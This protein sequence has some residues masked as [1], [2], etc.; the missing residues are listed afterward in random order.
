MGATSFGKLSLYIIRAFNKICAFNKFGSH[1]S[2]SIR[3]SKRNGIFSRAVKFGYAVLVL[4]GIFSNPVSAHTGPAI[5]EH[6]DEL[7]ELVFLLDDSGSMGQS[8][9]Q[10]QQEGFKQALNDIVDKGLSDYLNTVSVI[11]FGSSAS[12]EINQ[13]TDLSEIQTALSRAYNGGSTN[14]TGAFLNA[15]QIFNGIPDPDSDGH[16]VHKLLVLSTDGRP[17]S[18]SSALQAANQLQQDGVKIASVFVGSSSNSGISFL[19]SFSDNNPVP[20]PTNFNDFGSEVSE[21]LLLQ[22]SERVGTPVVSRF[23]TSVDANS[24]MTVQFECEGFAVGYDNPSYVLRYLDKRGNVLATRI[25]DSA[26]GGVVDSYTFTGGEGVYHASCA[27]RASLDGAVVDSPRTNIS[28]SIAF[29]TTDTDEDGLPDSWEDNGLLAANGTDVILDLPAMGANSQC[30]DVFVEVDWLVIQRAFRPDTSS[31]PQKGSFEKVIKAF[32]EAPVINPGGSACSGIN[33]HIDAGDDLMLAYDVQQ[34][35]VVSVVGDYSSGG[36]AIADNNQTIADDLYTKPKVNDVVNTISK[37]A[38]HAQHALHFSDNRN[39]VFRYALIAPMRNYSQSGLAYGA[40][41]AGFFSS[42]ES[43]FKDINRTDNEIASTFMHELGHSLGLGHGGIDANGN[44]DDENNKP[45][46]LSIMNYD[47]QFSWL[48]KGKFRRVRMDFSRWSTVELDE[49]DLN[50]NVGIGVS[51]PATDQIATD[52]LNGSVWLKYSCDSD[53]DFVYADVAE[54]SAIDWNCDG[55]SG[56]R[57]V[58]QDINLDQKVKS[59]NPNPPVLNKL[60][61]SQAS[62]WSQLSFRGVAGAGAGI[63]TAYQTLNSPRYTTPTEYYVEPPQ[64]THDLAVDGVRTSGMVAGQPNQIAFSVTNLGTS[65]DVYAVS[66]SVSS[67][68][69]T[70]TAN[71]VSLDVVQSQTVNSF[72]TVS[73][74]ANTPVGEKFTLSIKALSVADSIAEDSFDV[75]LEVRPASV[76]PDLD[77]VA[78]INDEL[79]EQAASIPSQAQL[80]SITILA[81]DFS[82]VSSLEGIANLSNLERLSLNGN[83]ITDLS[84]LIGLNQL[85][86]LLLDYNQISDLSPLASLGTITNLFLGGNQLSDISALASLTNLVSVNLSGN[87]ISDISPLAA[88]TGIKYLDLGYNQIV[89]ITA[90]ENLTQLIRLTL[91]QNQIQRLDALSDAVD[92]TYLDLWK[93]NIYNVTALSNLQALEELSINQ[94]N[95][96][97]VSPLFSL[98]SLIE[99]DVLLNCISDLSGF[100]QNVIIDNADSQRPSSDCD[101]PF[102]PVPI[103]PIIDLLL[104]D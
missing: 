48:G 22:L 88:S 96:Q 4:T 95:V 36:N 85:D 91:S 6:K 64:F 19:N 45:N 47:H 98:Q 27:I 42:G 81:C 51:A 49:N 14:M 61:G 53:N 63:V 67:N 29:D 101:L 66:V 15:S 7:I 78:C 24:P 13:G 54:N 84:A 35:K 94:N 73:V 30:K 75:E 38:W 99:I 10:L 33:L 86:W 58:V 11:Y 8:D 90:L 100:N 62:D 80:E 97:D 37:S 44:N 93:N 55:D 26:T 41:G 25:M 39:A 104:S 71:N 46:Y 1:A 82:G 16:K 77:L 18:S 50:E 17:D 32:A 23:E 56:D 70:A 89:D 34:D 28:F 43:W 3:V 72:I 60:S 9:F 65:D 12:V 87:S 103:A 69:V 68:L 102:K 21:L 74:P 57:N 52:L 76:L 79:G 2:N 59:N 31:R 5:K 20:T 40:P 92:L 83:Q